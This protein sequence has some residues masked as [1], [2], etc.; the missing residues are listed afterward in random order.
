MLTRLIEDVD[1]TCGK[2][3]AVILR[4]FSGCAEWNSH[5]SSVGCIWLL[6][7][8]ACAGFGSHV[9]LLTTDSSVAFALIII[10]ISCGAWVSS[11]AVEA[12]HVLS[13]KDLI[14]ASASAN[15]NHSATACRYV[16]PRPR[17]ILTDP[18]NRIPK[19]CGTANA[20]TPGQI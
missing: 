2:K 15:L 12:L 9:E 7:A 14:C 1:I 6:A 11:W 13:I 20:S 5:A 3:C 17:A 4:Q 18:V 8:F 19:L 10:I 16:D